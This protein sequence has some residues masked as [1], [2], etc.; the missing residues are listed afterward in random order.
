MFFLRASMV[1][2]CKSKA[3]FCKPLDG[4]PCTLSRKYPG[5]P[6]QRAFKCGECG[7]YRCA[8]HCRCG[9]NKTATGR[10]AARNLAA[11]AER[12]AKNK[13]R[14]AELPQSSTTVAG[15]QSFSPQGAPS[16]E[17]WKKLNSE[18]WWE[19]VF[20]KLSTAREAELATF[21]LHSS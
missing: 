3:V 13:P 17:F 11:Q 20:L 7:E 21:M 19:Q 6:S 16:K 4:T 14:T 1:K 12:L 9:R 8:E 5:Q 10:N 2:S 18:E 15:A